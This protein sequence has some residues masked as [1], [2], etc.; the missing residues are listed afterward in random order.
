MK[1]VKVMLVLFLVLSGF[2]GFTQNADEKIKFDPETN[3]K[4]R[5]Y[6]YPNLEA[7]FD[8]EKNTFTYKVNGKWTTTASIPSGYRGYS[9]FNKSNVAINDYDDDNPVQFLDQHRKKYPYT[10]LKRMKMTA[11]LH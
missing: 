8:M 4:I 9:L 5:Y 1:T 10:N 3:C 7:Y 11:S 6:Y 2:E